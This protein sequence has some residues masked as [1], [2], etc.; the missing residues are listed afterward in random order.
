[1]SFSQSQIVDT[2][3]YGLMAKSFA[4]WTLILTVCLL[5]IGFP[6]GILIVTFGSL[7][8]VALQAVVPGGMVIV[9]AGLIGL[10]LAGVMIGAAVLT[11]KGIHP[12]EVS[13]LR[14]LNGQADPQHETTY[15]ACPLTCEID[16]A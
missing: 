4:L 13:W 7:L 15:A 12:Q 2:A 3:D 9:A 6:V 5:I 10:Q 14:W 16:E 1:M 11:L 8:A